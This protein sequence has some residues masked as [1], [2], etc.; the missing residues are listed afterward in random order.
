[1]DTPQPVLSLA[2][3]RAWVNPQQ[4]CGALASWYWPGSTLWWC[5][6]H[7]AQVKQA[8]IAAQDRVA[9]ERQLQR[10]QAM[11][12][13]E[14]RP[15]DHLE[16]QRALSAQIAALRALEPSEEGRGEHA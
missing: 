9:L 3:C 15:V 1:M 14:P 16:Q 10:V 7:A 8:L 12:E 2:R 4:P 6:T 13:A 5:D 11:S